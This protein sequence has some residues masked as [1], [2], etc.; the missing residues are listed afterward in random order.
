MALFEHSPSIPV[1]LTTLCVPGHKLTPEGKRECAQAM[2]KIAAAIPVHSVIVYPSR[3]GSLTLP[4]GTGCMCSW[5]DA[6]LEFSR[7]PGAERYTSTVVKWF[8]KSDDVY[9]VVTSSGSVY[10][11]T[12]PQF[13]VF[14]WPDS[15]T[16]SH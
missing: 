7:M 4:D 13:V 11:F 12:A 15:S 16:E 10:T 6:V 8:F 14:H 9:H 2:I 1:N 5:K 3:T